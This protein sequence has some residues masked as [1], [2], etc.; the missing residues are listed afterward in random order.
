LTDTTPT[1]TTT[2]FSV[3]DQHLYSLTVLSNQLQEMLLRLAPSALPGS[4]HEQVIQLTDGVTKIR[5]Y[6]NVL[7]EERRSL[8]DLASIGQVIN[9]TLELDEVLQVVMDTLIRLTGAERGFLMLRGAD[10]EL[11]LRV[12]RNWEKGTIDASE[13][14][15]SSTVINRVVTT[16]VPILTT[17]A[18]ED[19]RFG[20]QQSVIAYN[21]R[22]I[23]CV[24]LRVKSEITG[25][26]YADNRIRSGLF[27]R[28][29][30]DLLAGF[31]NQA[32]VAIENARLFDSVRR[33][34]AEVTELKDLMDNVFASIASGVLTAN[35]DER[36]I[37]CNRAAETILGRESS[38]L[39]G[40]LLTQ[41]LEPLTEMLSPRFKHVVQTDEPVLGWE[42][43]P[44]LPD[45]GHVDLR[46]SLTPL[47]DVGRHTQGVAIV[48]DDLTEKKRLEAQRRLFERMVSPA[49]IEQLDPECLQLGGRRAEI[50]VLFADIRGFTSFSEGVTP[51]ELVQVLNRYLAAAAE[52]VLG[53]DG[54]VDKFLGDAVMA[55]FNAP[56]LQ[57]DHT[58]RAIRAALR[59]R[60]A[61]QAL[62]R[63]FPPRFQLAFGVGIH[64]G[65]AVLGLVGTEK[66]MEYTAIGDSV[67]TAKR[68]QENAGPS[69][70]LITESAYQLVASQI[71]V[72]P[73]EPIQAKGKR[74][75][76]PAYELLSLRQ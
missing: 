35:I 70:I 29:D 27:T 18:Q 55:W 32:A 43:S 40:N 46:L 62:H 5:Q 66:R 34:L 73:V 20:G 26:I 52:A 4:M 61:I 38:I 16:G 56:I 36:V 10:G 47:K 63:E 14:A 71:E 25:V 41:T 37:L 51:E 17:N 1:T 65:E 48:L 54:T 49:V 28:S 42:V 58:L 11:G 6:V 64:V 53:E 76:I 31:A 3:L 19:P 7:D 30:L 57:E 50:T 12:A 23:L 2:T 15:I 9:S 69:Q 60:D 72:R 68:V 74:A 8:R 39:V 67:N 45:R 44:N 33:T 59:I 24:P 13:T 21:L 22:S 75:P